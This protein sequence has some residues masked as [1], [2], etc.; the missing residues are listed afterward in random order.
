MIPKA[1][2]DEGE[3]DRH[4]KGVFDVAVRDGARIVVGHTHIV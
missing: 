2:A 4:V 1:Y 3:C